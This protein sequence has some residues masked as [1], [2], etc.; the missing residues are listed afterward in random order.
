MRE[1]RKRN[2][3]GG[4]VKRWVTEEFKNLYY[5][6]ERVGLVG[7]G[8]T[9]PRRLIVIHSTVHQILRRQCPNLEKFKEHTWAG[10][11]MPTV[12][13]RYDGPSMGAPDKFSANLRL[14][15]PSTFNTH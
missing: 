6:A 2:G 8:S 5:V 4:Y 10:Q 15:G 9:I 7:E 11:I 12:R 1:N 3:Y 14:F 13:R